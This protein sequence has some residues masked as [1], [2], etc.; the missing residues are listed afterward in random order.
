MNN[1]QTNSNDKN[2]TKGFPPA[3]GKGD[4]SGT[5]SSP[6]TQSNS[7]PQDGKEGANL[8]AFVMYMKDNWKVILSELV[9][10]G[11]TAYLAHSAKEKAAKN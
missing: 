5:L 6:G 4:G 3:Q 1:P 11:V 10:A 2:T 8:D 9:T 7:K